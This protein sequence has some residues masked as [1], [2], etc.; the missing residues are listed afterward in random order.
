MLTFASDPEVVDDFAIPESQQNT[1]RPRQTEIDANMQ[2]EV[3]EA[4]NPPALRSDETTY[5]RSGDIPS[6]KI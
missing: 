3:P 6:G 2:S 1:P 4:S 5:S